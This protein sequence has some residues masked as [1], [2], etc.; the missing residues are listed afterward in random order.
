MG[1]ATETSVAPLP[2]DFHFA[3]PVYN[4][5]LLSSTIRVVAVILDVCAERRASSERAGCSTHS[6][7]P[8]SFRA[9]RRRPTTQGVKRD[10]RERRAG[11]LDMA[12]SRASPYSDR[13]SDD[14]ARTRWGRLY[15]FDR[16]VRRL[17]RNTHSALL[18]FGGTFCVDDVVFS[19]ESTSIISRQAEVRSRPPS[20]APWRATDT[21]PCPSSARTRAETRTSTWASG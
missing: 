5:C 17:F 9:D 6:I 8:G 21:G 14:W 12:G 3:P 16:E 7:F 13:F 15:K 19:P 4:L 20:V 2:A 11:P 1:D 10:E 18:T